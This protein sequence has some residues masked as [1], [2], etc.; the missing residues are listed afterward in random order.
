MERYGLG[1]REVLE[2]LSKRNAGISEG[3]FSKIKN[4][5]IPLERVK[6]TTREALRD[7]F[8][9]SV[10]AWRELTGL[11]IPAFALKKTPAV[12]SLSEDSEKKSANQADI[13]FFDTRYSHEMTVRSVSSELLNLLA[14]TPQRTVIVKVRNDMYLE[15]T[16]R[17][18]YPHGSRLI[19]YTQRVP[20][21]G[22][23]VLI[24]LKMAN[25]DVYAVVEYQKTNP[26]FSIQQEGGEPKVVAEPDVEYIGVL[27]YGL[28]PELEDILDRLMEE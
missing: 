24:K 6:I 15:K 10:E 21:D 8:G 26:F 14:L 16:I 28:V 7:I 25:K 11:E 12:V 4:G 17:D 20:T 13:A 9:L 18:K 22:Q 1:N 2:E 5:K 19:F 27:A 3:Y 23:T